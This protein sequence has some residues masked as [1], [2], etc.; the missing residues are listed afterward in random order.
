MPA[1]FQGAS[2]TGLSTY[3]ST[4]PPGAPTIESNA[5]SAGGQNTA[6]VSGSPL[7]VYQSKPTQY[8]GNTIGRSFDQSDGDAINNLLGAITGHGLYQDI[9]AFVGILQTVYNPVGGGGQTSQVML[10]PRATLVAIRDAINMMLANSPTMG[11]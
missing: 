8:G 1:T 4:T 9:T 10:T 6:T 3:S 7:A 2:T 11:Q 5:T